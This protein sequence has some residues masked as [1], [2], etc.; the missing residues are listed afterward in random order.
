MAII[1]DKY[2]CELQSKE[3]LDVLIKYVEQNEPPENAPQ[4]PDI[5]D[6]ENEDP[7]GILGLMRKV[8]L[9]R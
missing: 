5:A 6:E 4:V 8:V 9:F 2:C 1:F 7:T 3:D